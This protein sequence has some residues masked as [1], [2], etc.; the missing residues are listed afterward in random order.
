MFSSCRPISSLSTR[1]V[2]PGPSP[3]SRCVETRSRRRFVPPVATAAA[4]APD[5]PRKLDTRSVLAAPA[6]PGSH[7]HHVVSSPHGRA[8][9][10]RPTNRKMRGEGSGGRADPFE[11]GCGRS[12]GGGGG[13]R[14]LPT[15]AA[16]A[17]VE[18]PP[19]RGRGP[20]PWIGSGRPDSSTRGVRGR[21]RR[22]FWL[23]GGRRRGSRSR[24]RFRRTA[25]T[26][27]GREGG[28]RPGR[29]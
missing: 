2:L 23:T 19:A 5:V 29:G 15:S 4:T 7:T 26:A 21:G 6:S 17:S 8:F 12:G 18:D 16:P 25:A 22:I 13:D 9:I 11:V 14:S 24:R 1:P 28:P 27:R 10:Q 3:A 20:P